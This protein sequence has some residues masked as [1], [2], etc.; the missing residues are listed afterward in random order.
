MSV[1]GHII[2]LL[3]CLTLREFSKHY[4]V[5]H[6]V[7]YINFISRILHDSLTTRLFSCSLAPLETAAIS[8]IA[9][10][11]HCA[12]LTVCVV[13]IISANAFLC[14]LDFAL[15]ESRHGFESSRVESRSDSHSTFSSRVFKIFDSY[16]MSRVQVGLTLDSKQRRSTHTRLALDS[17]RLASPLQ[18]FSTDTPKRL[19]HSTSPTL[20][21]CEM[22]QTPQRYHRS[23]S[24]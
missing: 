18:F 2:I 19:Q 5:L 23:T 22:L 17:T 7:R 21:C 8:I 12:A 9:P 15:A 24:S 16:S 3:T 4:Q 10:R 1:L 11:R 13:D 6:S 14:R 20:R